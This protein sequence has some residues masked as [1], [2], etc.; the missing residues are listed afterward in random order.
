MCVKKVFKHWAPLSEEILTIQMNHQ[1]QSLK[2][3]CGLESF[4]QVAKEE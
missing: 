1:E 4:S 3:S 2:G